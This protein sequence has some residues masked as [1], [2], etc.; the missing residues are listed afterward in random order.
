V[1]NPYGELP[2]A[3]GAGEPLSER[4]NRPVPRIVRIAFFLML[5]NVAV[6]A[7]SAI[8]L[9]LTRDQAKK[10]ILKKSPKLSEAAVSTTLTIATITSVVILLFLL[11]LAFKVR[12]G[13]N[14]ARIV[15]WVFAGI[16]ALGLLLTFTQTTTATNHAFTVVTG[17]INLA[18][19][20]LLATGESNRY[21]RR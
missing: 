18:I 21:F 6:E 10:A 11:F 4:G 13:A 15:T 17:L 7:I 19:I 9:V 16:G 2:Q 8:V 1:S 12:A 20:V 3:P 14:W 5:V